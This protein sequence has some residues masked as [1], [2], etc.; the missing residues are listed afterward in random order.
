MSTKKNSSESSEKS[1]T[2]S[3]ATTGKSTTKTKAASAVNSSQKT[4]GK[5]TTKMKAAT[6]VKATAKST[7]KPKTGSSSKTISKPAKPKGKK[8]KTN[9]LRLCS[10]MSKYAVDANDKEIIKRFKTTILTSTDD[11][12]KSNLDIILNT[13]NETDLSVFSESLQAYVKHYLFMVKRS[14]KMK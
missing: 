6:E 4:V 2:K 9:L 12:S 8:R 3:K 10:D 7:A 5:S 14:K 1:L 13:P 11:I